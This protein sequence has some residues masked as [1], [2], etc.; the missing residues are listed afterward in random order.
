MECNYFSLG[1]LISSSS[2]ASGF[3]R[4]YILQQ[5][6]NK[7]FPFSLDHWES[8]IQEANK[9]F[10]ALANVIPVFSNIYTIKILYVRR[11]RL[12]TLRR[13]F[14]CQDYWTSEDR[15]TY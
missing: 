12:V 10:T 4:C 3:D 6:W 14:I 7:A 5:N 11:W 13:Y 8:R 1:N 15:L 9:S 2:S